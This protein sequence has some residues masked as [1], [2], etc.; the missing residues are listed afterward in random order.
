L[1]V[2]RPHAAP[3]VEQVRDSTHLGVPAAGVVSRAV[4]AG[5]L[6][7]VGGTAGTI[8]IFISAIT[9]AAMS[10]DIGRYDLEIVP[11]EPEAQRILQGSRVRLS[12]EETY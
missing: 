4:P 3:T 9:T 2:D 8:T 7:V 11:S 6:E 12:T 10:F 5:C 1:H